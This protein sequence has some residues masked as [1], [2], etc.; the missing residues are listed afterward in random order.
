MT[1]ESNLRENIRFVSE[2]YSEYANRPDCRFVAYVK[3]EK[4]VAY[5]ALMDDDDLW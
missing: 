2:Q 1:E 5:V 4:G 3:I